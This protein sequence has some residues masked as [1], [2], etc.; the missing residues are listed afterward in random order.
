[1]S[2]SIHLKRK[3]LTETWK[4]YEQLIKA[5]GTHI[6]YRESWPFCWLIITIHKPRGEH[7]T[8]NRVKDR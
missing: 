8:Y 5:A 6:V 4:L 3:P 7:G 1:M 2:I